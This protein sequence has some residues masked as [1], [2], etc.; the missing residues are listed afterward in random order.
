MAKHLRITVDLTLEESAAID[1]LKTIAESIED[2]EREG[3]G[4]F[5]EDIEVAEPD[6]E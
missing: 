1:A 5:S 6:D 4:W 3:E 2:G